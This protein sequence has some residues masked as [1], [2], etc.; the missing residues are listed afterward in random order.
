MLLRL[1]DFEDD[2]DAAGICGIVFG[3]TEE[4][5]FLPE[6]DLQGVTLDEGADCFEIQL[7]GPSV[8]EGLRSLVEHGLAEEVGP[9]AALPPV[10]V[11]CGLPEWMYEAIQGGE[12]VV[13]LERVD[14]AAASANGEGGPDGA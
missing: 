6:E 9:A 12:T 1:R 14:D 10:G 5:S 3:N 11:A 13:E 2:V 8:F 7:D 4:A